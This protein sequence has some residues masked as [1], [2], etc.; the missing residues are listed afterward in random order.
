MSFQHWLMNNKHK[1][2][3]KE[4]EKLIEDDETVLLV[5]NLFHKYEDDNLKLIKK[6]NMG[7]TID[8][9]RIKG[10][11]KQTINAHGVIN[12]RLIGSATKRIYG[13]LLDENKRRFKLNFNSFIIGAVITY[14][15]MLI[16][17]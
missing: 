4:L 6:L 11:L 16:T 12:S 8:T 15:I 3:E 14:I 9:N 2:I 10:A 1:K 7:K 17:T 13:A 5:L